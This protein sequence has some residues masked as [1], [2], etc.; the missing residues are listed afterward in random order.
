MDE[1]N[2]LNYKIFAVIWKNLWRFFLNRV[3]FFPTSQIQS[4]CDIVE[5]LIMKRVFCFIQVIDSFYC[6]L[7]ITTWVCS[8]FFFNFFLLLSQLLSYFHVMHDST[9]LLL[10]TES[11]IPI[12]DDTTISVNASAHSII[13]ETSSLG[14]SADLQSE[15]ILTS[16]AYL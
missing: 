9:T 7:Y 3:F 13:M 12:R 6:K 16:F 2:F 10:N 4:K 1:T 11:R 15:Y 5:E 14:S 8:I